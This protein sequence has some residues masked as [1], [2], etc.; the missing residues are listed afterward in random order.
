MKLA[1]QDLAIQ[2]RLIFRDN[3]QSKIPTYSRELESYVYDHCFVPVP[4]LN[5]IRQ[6][7][8]HV[9]MNYMMIERDQAAFLHLL[10]KT[11]AARRALEIGCYLGYGTLAIAS[12]LPAEGTVISIDHN[13]DWSQKAQASFERADLS[14]KINLR[15]GEAIAEL[16]KLQA[17][18]LET[19]NY[20]DI[21]FIDADKKN[22]FN[23]YLKCINLLR[24]G[25]IMLIDNILWR[26]HILDDD[27]QSDRIQALRQL[28]DFIIADVRVDT[29][30][31]TLS[32]GMI[33]ARKK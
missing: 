25:G 2:Q 29:M 23:Y 6:E 26:G 19:Q 21:I 8:A 24:S 14:S 11:A 7:A 18:I 33:F 12:A 22:S 31:L 13:P 20:F 17:E 9:E 10:T 28:N 1:V 32:D 5:Q 27:D 30:I 16:D 3:H 15:V 4:T